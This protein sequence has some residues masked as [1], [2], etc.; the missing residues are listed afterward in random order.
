V[1]VEMVEWRTLNVQ[2]LKRA[3]THV[4][5]IHFIVE[6]S[7]VDPFTF[8]LFLEHEEISGISI[9][10]SLQDLQKVSDNLRA[11]SSSCYVLA[12]SSTFIEFLTS[13]TTIAFHIHIYIDRLSTSSPKLNHVLQQIRRDFALYCTALLARSYGYKVRVD[14]IPPDD[15]LWALLDRDRGWLNEI[16]RQSL[17]ITEPDEAWV[18]MSIKPIP[19]EFIESRQQLLRLGDAVFE[20][21]ILTRKRAMD[22]LGHPVMLRYASLEEIS[23]LRSLIGP[24]FDVMIDMTLDRAN[25]MPKPGRKLSAESY[26][27]LCSTAELE[28]WSDVEVLRLV[29][30]HLNPVLSPRFVYH[31]SVVS[32]DDWRRLYRRLKSSGRL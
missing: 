2:Q 21:S 1:V 27:N 6:E 5:G 32:G 4:V 14:Q 12:D 3:L 10:L 20:R 25:A 23:F 19:Y 18:P 15:A 22:L 13:V 7:P 16:L 9:G 26:S 24:S 11:L 30:E 31:A 28:G 17:D 29:D 8:D